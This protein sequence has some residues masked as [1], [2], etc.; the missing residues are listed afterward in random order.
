MHVGSRNQRYAYRH[1]KLAEGNVKKIWEAFVHATIKL[2]TDLFK[3]DCDILQCS[4][5]LSFFYLTFIITR[6]VE[7]LLCFFILSCLCFIF[8]CQLFF[9]L[10]LFHSIFYFCVSLF[11]QLF[12]SAFFSP[13]GLYSWLCP[14]Q[15]S[16][17]VFLWL[18]LKVHFPCIMRIVL[19][20]KILLWSYLQGGSC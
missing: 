18:F 14:P 4:F 20:S 17:F 2:L 3:K 19:P 6:L 8:F 10:Y 5:L 13:N 9:P 12:H 15:N 1:V 7:V 16:S 11:L